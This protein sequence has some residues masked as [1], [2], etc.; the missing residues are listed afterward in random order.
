MDLGL[1]E[2]NQAQLNGRKIQ[3]PQG[4]AL[5][6]SSVINAT[7][8]VPPSR[9]I[10]DSWESLGNPGW[11][12]ETLMPYYAKSYSLKVPGGEIAKHLGIEWTARA[13]TT[14]GPLRVSHNGTLN[15]PLPK[16]WIESLRSLGYEMKEDPFSGPSAGS[17]SSLSTVD[18]VLKERSS[19]ATAYYTPASG[20]RNLHVLTGGLVEK[21]LFM[22][23][24]NELVASGI[25]FQ[26]NG[27]AKVAKVR[28]EVILA[29][30]SLQSPKILELSGIGNPEILKSHGIEVLIDNSNVGE[31]FQDHLFCAMPFEVREMIPTL[32]DVVRGNAEATET[33]FS[34]Y[35]AQKTGLFTSVGVTSY[36]YLPVVDFISLEGQ[37]SL[38]KLL[39]SY[40]DKG[41]KPAAKGNFEVA[42]RI[43]E[44]ENDASGMFATVAAQLD[45]MD[46]PFGNEPGNFVSITATLSQPLST[47]S[48]HSL[49]SISFELS[50]IQVQ[51]VSSFESSIASLFTWTS[52]VDLFHRAIIKLIPGR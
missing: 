45:V 5:G 28:K 51:D 32:D 48:V 15:D 37:A 43:L 7:M 21:I 9:T 2:S 4:R 26:Q 34:E 10:I 25:R 29:A 17:F 23:S 24:E 46:S 22:K 52:E 42:R 3:Y 50:S 44:N 30:G 27:E 14:A 38:K 18:P 12:W 41:N 47:G 13:P 36:A 8:F 1:S 31:N 11:N 19:S 16:A 35:K 39:D 6:G 40:I 20:R 49:Y 33:A